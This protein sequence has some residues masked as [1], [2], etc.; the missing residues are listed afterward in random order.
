M[1]EWKT[2]KN[3]LII[4]LDNMGDLIM[5]NAAFAEIKRSMPSC[6]MTL[7]TSSVAAPIVP[8]LG[9][10]DETLVYDSPWMK[11]PAEARESSFNQLI[12]M[13]AARQF[14]SCIIFSVYSQNILPAAMLAYLAGIP[15]RAGYLRENPYQLLSHWY[16]D[17]EPYLT[18]HHQIKRDL[19][20]LERISLQVDLNRLPSLRKA[21]CV[22]AD[23][24]KKLPIKLKRHSYT[25]L[26]LEVSEEK[27][28][29]PVSDAMELLEVL[30]N[31]KERVILTGNKRDSQFDSYLL[32]LE[33]AL[34]YLSDL[35]GKSTL[36][37]L[38]FLVE[39]AKGIISV[40]TS[41]LHMACA[42]QRPLLAL[43]ADSNPQHLPWQ[44]LARSFIFSV[45]APLRSKN[46]VI[47]YVHKQ[48]P[49]K[50]SPPATG[51]ELVADY[52]ALLNENKA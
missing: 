38:L 12:A 30:L 9:T 41:V 31:K 2:C 18:M 11:G 5:N 23:I 14:D 4:R 6:K 51:A 50:L 44:Q 22:N 43:Y 1:G 29:F 49:L 32:K 21:E 35:R 13:L 40:N 25:L 20:L 19:S 16:P 52:L 10:I 36:G 15:L 47:A 37:Q 28:S 34:S 27:R 8:Y 17:P 39:N 3:M 24:A 26:H 46:Q 7:L 33:P 45:A 42:Y 48:N